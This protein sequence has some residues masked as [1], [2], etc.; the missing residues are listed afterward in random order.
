MNDLELEQTRTRF[1]AW[2]QLV[3]YRDWKFK[4]SKDGDRL[5]LQLRWMG[6]CTAHDR[7]EI[8]MSRKWMLSPYMTKSE[9][10]QTCLKA[11]LTAV[12]HEA[13]ESF[14]YK[15]QPVYRPHYNVDALHSL[16]EAKALDYRM[17]K[18]A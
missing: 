5:F 4:I 1:F 2:L 18:Q 10:I 14:K 16:C 11:V 8:Q 17:E 7:P 3:E 13:R 12:E 9:F 15:N 6:I